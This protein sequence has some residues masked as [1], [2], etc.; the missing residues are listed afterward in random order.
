MLLSLMAG[1]ALMPQQPIDLSTL[2]LEGPP[3]V[4]RIAERAADHR[5]QVLVAEPVEGADGRQ[6]LL[7]SSFGDVEDYFYPASSV[8]LFAAIAALLEVD[9]I[10]RENGRAFGLDSAWRIAPR[11]DGDDWIDADPSNLDGGRLTIGHELRKLFLYSDNAA[12]NHCFE[13]VGPRRINE[14]M[15]R[16]GVQTCRLWHRLSE[17]HPDEEMWQTRAVTLVGEGE[18]LVVPARDDVPDFDNTGF[19]RLL[20]GKAYMSR[21]SRVDEPMSFA[22]KNAVR[23]LDLQNAL[24]AVVRPDLDLGIRGFPELRADHRAFLVAT[25]GMLPRESSNPRLDA[26]QYPDD[27]V[28]LMLEGLRR[29]VPEDQLKVCNK[30]GRAYGFTIENAWV[31]D[32]YRG[33]GF[34]VSV[35]LYTNPDGVLNDDRY[36]YEELADPFFRELGELLARAVLERGPR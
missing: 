36:A 31:E 16:A 8:K 13:F 25:M 23:L 29:V 18:D 27:Y 21:G 34:F 5:L 9:R 12:Y 11:F 28:K 1:A 32:C 24:A 10:N 7:R 2:M 4:V 6:T 14:L 17:A 15:W 35:A 20:E 19:L 3:A 33:R 30:T 22:R 26:E